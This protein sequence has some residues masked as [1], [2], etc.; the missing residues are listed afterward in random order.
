MA[1]RSLAVS[2]APWMGLPRPATLGCRSKESGGSLASPSLTGKDA[3]MDR[4]KRTDRPKQ[5]A[6]YVSRGTLAGALSCSSSTLRRMERNG[7]IKATMIGNR[8]RYAVT[9]LVA[10]WPSL[11]RLTATTN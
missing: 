6:C 4:T 7:L 5:R 1:P 11:D 2:E 9:E 3:I 10:I 8:P